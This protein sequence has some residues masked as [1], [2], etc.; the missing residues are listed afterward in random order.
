MEVPADPVEVKPYAITITPADIVIYTGG[1][2]YSGVLDDAGDFVGSME[3]GLPE[4]GYHIDLPDSVEA[5]LTSHGVDLTQAANLADYLS[6]YYYD[7]E[8]GAAI[9]RWDLMDQGVYSRDATGN[10]SLLCI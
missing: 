5:W 3:Q 4:P 10:V 1:T 2:G 6:F 8:T 9:R 7:Q